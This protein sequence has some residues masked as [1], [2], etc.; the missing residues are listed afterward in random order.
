MDNLELIRLGTEKLKNGENLEF[1]QIISSSGSTPRG[2]DAFMLIGTEGCI[3]GT[4]GGG[5]VE[6]LAQKDAAEFLGKEEDGEKPYNL[7]RG[8]TE[9]IGMICG[10]DVSISFT[11]LSGEDGISFLTEKEKKIRE[12]KPV[13]W[14]WL[15]PSFGLHG[16][17]GTGPHGLT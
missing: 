12:G 7:S 6:F 4:V 14:L 11:W 1:A 17:S 15:R 9:S 13:F 5:S 2:N 3:G 8:K 10:G 16:S